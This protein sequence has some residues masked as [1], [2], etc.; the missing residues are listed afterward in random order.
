MNK[1]LNDAVSEL[2]WI[3]ARADD[4]DAGR[5]EKWSECFGIGTHELPQVQ[6]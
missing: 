1:V 3:A 2:G 4:G 6:E 5:L